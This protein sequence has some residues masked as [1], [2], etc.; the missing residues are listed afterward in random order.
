MKNI[1]VKHLKVFSYFLIVIIIGLVAYLVVNFV[2]I[3]K[4]QSTT[5]PASQVHVRVV[6]ASNNQNEASVELVGIPIRPHQTVTNRTNTTDDEYSNAIDITQE[7]KFTEAFPGSVFD[8]A[9]GDTLTL[10]RP[11]CDGEITEISFTV[12][13]ITPAGAWISGLGRP[14]VDQ[15]L[16]KTAALSYAGPYCGEE[17]HQWFGMSLGVQKETGEPAIFN[18][19]IF[20]DSRVDGNYNLG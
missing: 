16:E 12:E 8:L 2:E 11:N 6:P 14:D 19:Y 4:S 9:V 18:A 3:T 13:E 5:Q 10:K 7:Y 1:T 20:K 17:V 15:F